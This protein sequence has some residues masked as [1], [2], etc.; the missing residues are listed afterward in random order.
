[1]PV[2]DFHLH[3]YE[4]PL[5]GPAAFFA[6]LDRQI[7]RPFA[8]V[9]REHATTES[10]LGVLDGAGVDVGVVLAEVAPITSGLCSNERVAELC[11]GTSRLIPFGS[12]I[13]A[14]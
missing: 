8:E 3:A 9:A 2:V 14:M 13:D 10:Y 4:F 1:M 11:R 6:F 7:G 12:I 5:Q